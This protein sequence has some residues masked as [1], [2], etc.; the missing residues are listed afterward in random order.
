MGRPAAA[1]ASECD[2]GV[3][4]FAARR[5]DHSKLLVVQVLQNLG[6][7]ME[8][9]RHGTPVRRRILNF[10]HLLPDASGDMARSYL[11]GLFAESEI[12]F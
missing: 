9:M 4:F 6:L 11:T 2:M 10:V 7:L 5:W 12:T 3:F 8:G 1:P